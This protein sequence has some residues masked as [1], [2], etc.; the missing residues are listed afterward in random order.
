MRLPVVIAASLILIGCA[1]PYGEMG[2]MGGVRAVRIT[3]DT[4]QITA[5]GNAYTDVDT[6]Q[7]YALRRAAEETVADGFDLFKVASSADRTATGEQS[8]GSAYGNRFA[9]FGTSTSMPVIKPGQSLMIKMVHGPRPDPMPDGEFDA[10]EVLKY[11]AGADASRDHRD[12]ST[13]DGKVVCK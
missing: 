8:F 1:T 4:A 2:Y 3:D 6:I 13:I 10:R 9:L 12:C 11:L 7:R 5:A